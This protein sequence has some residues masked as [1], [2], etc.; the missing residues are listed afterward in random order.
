MRRIIFVI[1]R[2]A[3][4][5]DVISPSEVFAAAK[6]RSGKDLYQ[7]EMASVGGGPIA[8]CSGAA[9]HTQD[10]LDIAPAAHDTVLVA[11]GFGQAVG[12]AMEDPAL[13]EWLQRA[14]R[15]VERMSRSDRFSRL[16][17]RQHLRA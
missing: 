15:R 14:A 11:G 17:S 8:T 1:Y 10:L 4:A 3:A 5:L 2:G 9:I 16:H 12:P 13:L 6:R 7:L